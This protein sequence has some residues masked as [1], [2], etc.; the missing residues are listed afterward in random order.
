MSPD[1]CVGWWFLLITGLGA[2]GYVGGFVGFNIKT[3]GL[4]VKEVLQ[5]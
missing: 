1:S 2:A 4:S 5:P 3:K